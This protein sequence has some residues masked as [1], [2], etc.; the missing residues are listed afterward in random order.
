M[1]VSFN[2]IYFPIIFIQHSDYLE[3]DELIKNQMSANTQIK[4]FDYARGEVSFNQKDPDGLEAEQLDEFLED[5]RYLISNEHDV[6]ILL[7]DF[8]Y[9]LS[10]P[11]IQPKVIGKLRMLAQ[12]FEQKTY[13]SDQ[14]K[15][16]IVIVSQRGDLPNELKPY[17]YVL[18]MMPP[19]IEEIKK[20]ILQFA[21]SM[22]ISLD[23]EFIHRVPSQMLKLERLEIK[24]ILHTYFHEHRKLDLSIVN[25]VFEMRKQNIRKTG[26][27]EL[28]EVPSDLKV[29]GL[30][31]LQHWLR[32]KAKIF[33][34]YDFEKKDQYYRIQ[35][36][37]GVL[38]VGVPGSGKSH[39][40]KLTSNIFNAPLIR[41]D[42]GS[43]LG[44]YVGDSE[45]N[46]KRALKLA[47]MNS[48]CILWIDEIEK[49]FSNVG[50]DGGHE[51]TNRIFGY[52]LTWLQEHKSKV[53]IV[54]TANDISKLPPEFLRKGRFDDI[55]IVDL[56]TLH[57][58]KQIFEL[59]FE[60]I[61][62]IAKDIDVLKLAEKTE[63]FTS[64]DIPSI[65]S[66]MVEQ[67]Y[68]LN[69][70]KLLTNDFIEAIEE[71]ASFSKVMEDKMDEMKKKLERIGARRAS[72]VNAANPMIQRIHKLGEHKKGTLRNGK[73][74]SIVFTNNKNKLHYSFGSSNFMT[75]QY[76]N[77]WFNATSIDM[78]LHQLK[79][80][81]DLH[82]NLGGTVL[83]ASSMNKV[84][85]L[86]IPNLQNPKEIYNEPH[87]VSTLSGDGKY[88][89]LAKDN[90][91]QII[92]LK[93]KKLIKTLSHLI[94]DVCQLAFQTGGSQLAVALENDEIY[95][96]ESTTGKEIRKLEGHSNRITKLI[97]EKNMLVSS[98]KDST[99]KL[100]DLEKG[101]YAC[102][103]IYESAGP[104]TD[105]V[106]SNKKQFAIFGNTIG[107]IF[108]YDVVA[109]MIV[110]ILQLPDGVKSI[111]LALDYS[112]F[113]VVDNQLTIHLW[114]IEFN[115][116]KEKKDEKK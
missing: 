1:M 54:A 6:V 12:E 29:A 98:S 41:F 3:V 65:V 115:K 14:M 95:I 10:E 106:Y 44:K 9:V 7:K 96:Y 57:E 43:L 88:V 59:Q 70:R 24:R 34:E 58:R 38:I 87:D 46:M 60:E 62:N 75:L 4:E 19:T 85:A 32:K 63:G 107:T 78:Q 67:A 37:R 80:L 71:F 42:I 20:I 18:E 11:Y 116:E 35:K 45:Y 30:S 92:E 110:E 90:K 5:C 61:G 94:D 25:A 33:K 99:V 114:D 104:I 36:P 97:F 79:E 17:T 69:K 91:V 55:Y 52:F 21:K 15:L 26:V 102:R 72:N 13:I 50:S 28:V 89:A 8:H 82:S 64:S 76:E 16:K 112:R 111:A 68:Y 93:T 105:I 74:A 49:A 113:A 2:K 86:E 108:I 39:S 84:I 51:T 27:L 101:D 81:S 22:R 48:P 77:E 66:D 109:K 47:E 100:W 31:E 103:T 73:D 53:F 56:P 83:T 40:A 23:P